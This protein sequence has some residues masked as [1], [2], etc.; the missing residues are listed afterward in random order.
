MSTQANKEMVRQYFDER[1]N[2]GNLE[3][4]D[5]MLAP[6]LDIEGLKEWTRSMFTAFGNIRIQILSILAEDDQVAVHWRV[7]AIHQGEFLGVQATGKLISYQGIA[8]I[9]IV[10][11]KIVDDTAY[12]DNLEIL[13]QLGVAL[14]NEK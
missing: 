1:W 13:K 6:S 7:E 10:K 11:G 4:Y 9:S 5:A 8:I 12:W 2:H 14:V 3:V